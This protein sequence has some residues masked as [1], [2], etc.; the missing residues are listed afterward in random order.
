MNGDQRGTNDEAPRTIE[1]EVAPGDVLTV[2]YSETAWAMLE[3][4]RAQHGHEAA[5]RV[6]H[7]TWSP[8]YTE[9]TIHTLQIVTST[10]DLQ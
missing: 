10:E 1:L 9:R 8:D 3:D 2:H 7:E 4:Y 6:T 5:Y